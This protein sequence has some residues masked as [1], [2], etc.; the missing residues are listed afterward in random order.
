MTSLSTPS[1]LKTTAQAAYDRFGSIKSQANNGDARKIALFSDDFYFKWNKLGFVNGEKGVGLGALI[2]MLEM[3]TATI[4]WKIESTPATLTN[5][6]TTLSECFQVLISGYERT[7]I[8]P[9]KITDS[10]EREIAEKKLKSR[11][12]KRSL[13]MA[14]VITGAGGGGLWKFLKETYESL[15]GENHDIH[16]VPFWQKGILSISSLISA[17]GMSIGYGEKSLMAALA[18]KE[19]GGFKSDQMIQNAKSDGRCAIEWFVMTT[20]L[21]FTQ[22][23]PVKFIFDLGLPLNA[24]HD[25]LSHLLEPWFEKG[26]KHSDEN[27]TEHDHKHETHGHNNSLGEGKFKQLLR[28]IFSHD[29]EIRVPKIYFNKLFFGSNPDGGLRATLF[30]PLFRLFGCNPPDCHINNENN[31][32]VKINTEANQAP[33]PVLNKPSPKSLPTGAKNSVAAA[34]T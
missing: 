34:L 9:E 13:A 5:A 29:H 22:L 27:C 3:V 30:K 26:H 6:L 25:G 32:V 14:A 15:K 4:L 8:N 24:L 23:K 19:N 28:K 20:Y 21:Y 10:R 33:V 2:A 17:I 1:V 12:T 31:V 16:E 11:E 7:K 18:R